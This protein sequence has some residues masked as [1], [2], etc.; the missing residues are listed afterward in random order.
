VRR[1]WISRVDLTPGP[2]LSHP[3]HVLG[4]AGP[5]IF[6]AEISNRGY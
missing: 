5:G 3:P 2:V 4:Q 1:Y 6:Q